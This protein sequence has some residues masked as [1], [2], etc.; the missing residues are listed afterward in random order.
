MK[1]EKMKIPSANFNSESSLPPISV[2]LSLT[3][4]NS[5]LFT[6]ERDGLFV[7]Y[8][9]VE[10]AFPYKYIDMYDRALDTKEYETVVLEN[11]YLKATFTP[12]FGG[13]LW[14]LID[15]TTGK[16]LLFSNSVVRPCNI[17]VRN[18]WLDGGIEWNCGF[19]GHHPFTCSLINTAT[20]TLDDG[21]PVLRFYYFERIRAVVVQ[22]DFFLPKGEKF[23]Y[24]RVRITNPN[25]YVVPMYWWSNIGVV[26]NPGDRVIVPA[27]RSYTALD[28][29]IMKVDIPVYNNTDV[30]YP[31]NNTASNDYFWDI[32]ENQRKY[33]CQLNSEG[34]GLCQTSTS[35]LRG[36]KLF[37]WGNSQGGH[38]WMNFLTDD[39]KTGRYDEIQCG[40]ARTQY[41]CLPMPPHTVWE[42]S[43]AYGAMQADPEKVHSDWDVARGEVEL[44]LNEM[45]TAEK[46]EKILD[47]TRA[48]AKRPAE[49]ILH[50]VDAW[51]ALELMRRKKDG[52]DLMCNHLDFGEVG[53]EQKVWI[54]LMENGT[55]GEHSPEDVPL[56]YNRQAP[57]IDML[58]SAIAAKDKDNWYAYYLLGCAEVAE[59]RYDI[60]KSY[61]KTSLE[62]CDSP[63]ANYAM[64]IAN[65][66]SGQDDVEYMLKAYALRSSDLSLAKDM[67]RCLFEHE[68]S[69]KTLE[70]FDA[71]TDEIKSNARCLLYYAYALA[72][73][74]RIE[75][76]ENIICPDGGYL[77]VPD[78]RE[79]ELTITQ[80]WVYIQEQKG[81]TR[82]TM[83]EIPR[84][85]DFRMFAKREG[86]A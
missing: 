43:E 2:K 73:L 66:K 78:V 63:W 41:E 50:S 13:K 57:W 32:P 55:V 44:K 47:D 11:E 33:I 20:T 76:A 48:M 8:G 24:T 81:L 22:M 42:W 51:G 29:D 46:L 40:L 71:A 3:D 30:T 62:L 34:Y 9:V 14:S 38:K 58:K 37:I 7:N 36:R 77:V 64:A 80:L 17:A 12:E 16:E 65:K 83:G 15:K 35:L 26:E 72:R 53:E 19:R 59:E 5:K 1:I 67:F 52:E 70:L 6:D 56:S 18:A 31:A 75:E 25:D 68:L 60:A 79:C 84:D 82:A 10:C 74:G 54:D 23:L 86:W 4:M 85:L 45:I 28:G 49:K 69:E 61:L 39:S 27:T 21:T